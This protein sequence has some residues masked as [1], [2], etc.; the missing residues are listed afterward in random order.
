[1]MATTAAM[2][3]QFNKNNILI[4]EGMGY[5]VHVLGNFLVGN[6]ISIERL[7]SF[8]SW[9]KDHKGK[10]FHY[11]A[12][13]KP[14][15][16][17]NNFVAYQYA[18]ELIKK[19]QYDFIHC[20]TP[21]GSVIARIAA[22]Q[23]DTKIIYTAHGFHFFKGAPLR[24]WI[25]YYPVE[26]FLSK[27]TDVLVLINKEDYNLAVS[28]FY[29]KKTIYIPGVGI[30]LEINKE[31]KK[32][33]FE[34]ISQF[35]L[36]ENDII[37]LSVGELNKN[38]NHQLVVRALKRINDDRLHYFIAGQGSRKK[39]ILSLAK[40]L[41]VEKHIHLLGYQK[42][43]RDLDAKADIFVFPSLREGLSVALM[44]AIA[45]KTVV[46][47]SDI[48]GNSDLIKDSNYLFDPHSVSSLVHSLLVTLEVDNKEIIYENESRL[49]EYDARN[50]NRMMQDVYR[51]QGLNYN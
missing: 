8:K 37:I 22:H 34:N 51:N 21:L 15:N 30:N 14:T 29:A 48:R 5:E 3:E 36:K 39:D 40:K 46:V 50:V 1:M 9:I 17:R 2:I 24:N 45:E 4:L 13:R 28:R 25:L 10:W 20:H 7:E 12:T 26:K 11:P 42:N 33:S 38:K 43:I 6:P 19:Y 49:Q 41:G 31:D 23:T 16:F 18:V 44:E 32:I 47:C 27:W 35:Q